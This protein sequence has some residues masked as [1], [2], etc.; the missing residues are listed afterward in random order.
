MDPLHEFIKRFKSN[1]YNES[2]APVAFIGH[3]NPTNA[4]EDNSFS[5]TW[6]TIGKQIPKPKAIVVISAHWQTN[7]TWI[8]AM[9]NPRTI[10]DFY[11]FPPPMYYQQYPAPG[12]PVLTNAIVEQ[13][14]AIFSKDFDWGFD[15]GTWSVLKPMFPDADIPTIQISLDHTKSAEHHFDLAKKLMI[16]RS[17][18]VMILG[19]GN[20]VHNLSLVKFSDDAYDWAIEFDETV[21]DKIDQRN[22]AD[23]IKYEKLGQAAQLSIPTNEH[24]LPMLY[25][26]SLLRDNEDL[27]YFNDITIMGSI[28]MRSFIAG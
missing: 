24:Y 27:H 6:K 7:G 19:S 26:L 28:S 5:R 22:F 16:L 10:H 20:I 8:T 12:D 17:R 3:G 2:L 13:N 18:G 4:I 23:L 25:V 1:H 9:E 11:G 15:H 21:R 14:P